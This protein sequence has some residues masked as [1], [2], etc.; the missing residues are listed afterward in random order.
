MSK[1]KGLRKIWREEQ[2]L[3]PFHKVISTAQTFYGDGQDRWSEYK[4]QQRPTFVSC[5]QLGL[6]DKNLKNKHTLVKDR[7][8]HSFV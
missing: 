5:V 4:P 1:A 8:D 7:K 3:F 6:E 2:R